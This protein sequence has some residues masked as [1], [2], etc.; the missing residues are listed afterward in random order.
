[1]VKILK[2]KKIYFFSKTKVSNSAALQ[3]M[4]MK[5][6]FIK[7]KI[8]TRIFRNFYDVETFE[9]QIHISKSE[10]IH[11]KKNNNLKKNQNCDGPKTEYLHFTKQKS[12]LIIYSVS[13][14]LNEIE[15]GFL[16]W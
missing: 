5:Y 7:W 11:L 6:I 8:Y 16:H 9:L 3:F 10:T 14:V 1:M 12:P 13:I 4:H 2:N 15:Y